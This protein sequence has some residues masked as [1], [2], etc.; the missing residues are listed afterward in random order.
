MCIDTKIKCIAS[1][2]RNW[3]ANFFEEFQDLLENVAT[4]NSELYIP[5]NFN[6]HL[7]HSTIT[8]MFDDIQHPL[9]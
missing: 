6:I 4:N 7:E 8:T 1:L 9:I 5:G 3:P 2:Q